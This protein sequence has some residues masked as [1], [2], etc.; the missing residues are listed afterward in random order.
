MA[1]LARTGAEHSYAYGLS[2]LLCPRFG[3]SA[4]NQNPTLVDG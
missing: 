4:G 3:L 1:L 2:Q